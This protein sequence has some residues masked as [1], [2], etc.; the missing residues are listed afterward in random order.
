MRVVMLT[1]DCQMIDRRILQEAATLVE[2]GHE[3]HL[4]G[5]FECAQTADYLHRGVHVH[6]LTYDWDDERLKKIRSYLPANDR[7]RM[8]VNRTFMFFARRFFRVS[9]FERFIMEQ[10]FAYPSDIVHVHD[11]PMLKPGLAVAKAW[12]V[13]LV[14]DAHELYYAQDVLP[15]KMQRKYYRLEKKLIRHVDLAITVNEHIAR[16]MSERYGVPAPQ[17]L[18]NA[19]DEPTDEVSTEPGLRER[20]GGD[21]PIVLFQGWISAE[22]NIETIVKAVPFMAEPA[23]LAI[24]GYGAHEATLRQIAKDLGVEHR[25]RFLG[26]VPSDQILHLTRGADLGVIPYLPIDDNHR[27]CSPNKFFEYVMAGVP[28]LAHELSFFQDMGKRHGVVQCT[29]FTSP[30]KVGRTI[31]ELLREGKLTAMQRSCVEARKV[32]NWRTEGEK[33]LKMYERFTKAE[34]KAA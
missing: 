4:L 31:S 28:I 14:Y 21:G 27:Y 18:Y 15:V 32:L 29:D 30:E 20:V 23:V 16:L 5:G 2:A 11:L 9:P 12:G 7:V 33:L 22:R 25:V 17:V 6:R 13:P 3:V 34:R 10:A 8:L 24:I 26:A 1:N 19:A